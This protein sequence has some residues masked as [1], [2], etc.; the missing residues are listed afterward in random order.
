MQGGTRSALLAAAAGLLRF[1]PH[2]LV[3]LL[4]AA[5]AVYSVAGHPLGQAA[6]ACK[7]L[8]GEQRL[9]VGGCRQLR[10]SGSPFV[11]YGC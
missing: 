3:V 5:L 8:W 11:M 6:A 2:P 9:V 4:P 1:P 7:P 10:C